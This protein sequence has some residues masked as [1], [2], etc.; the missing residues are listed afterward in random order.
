PLAALGPRLA[1]AGVPAVIAMQGKVSLDTAGRFMKSFFTQLSSEGAID[2]AVAVARG[3]V[4]EAADHWMPV[5]FMRLRSGQIWYTP[6]FG[7]DRPFDQ[8]P[9]ITRNITSGSC[10]PII[11]PGLAESI[12]GSPREIAGRWAAEYNFPLAPHQRDDL[13]SVA[14][15]LSVNQEPQFPRYEL[16]S[17]LRKELVARYGKQFPGD[18]SEAPLPEIFAAVSAALRE[19]GQHDPHQV[20][21]ELPFAVYVTTALD[22]LL[23]EALRAAGKAPQIEL[24]RWNEYLVDLPSV[25]EDTPDYKPSKE[26]PLVFH[27]YGSVDNEDSLV[28]TEDDYFDYLIGA[29]KNRELIPPAVRAALV[30]RAL[31]FLGFRLEDWSFRVLF[32]SLMSDEGGNRRKRYT[33]IA[34]QIVPE[35]GQVLSPGGVA[36][37]LERYFRDVNIDLFWGGADDFTRELQREWK[38]TSAR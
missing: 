24:C 21:A 12:L 31:L 15:F 4:R 6:G 5:L 8:W 26:Q 36:R 23:E 29:T 3:E 7:G 20:M 1:E 32:R 2:G 35:D 25:F 27:L 22:T 34:G 19:R 38:K 10:T 28:L 30:D 18:L 37:Y 33:N 14:Q 17:Y 11:G 13:A 16:L 9:K